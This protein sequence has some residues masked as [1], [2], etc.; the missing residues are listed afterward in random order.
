MGNI[1]LKSLQNIWHYVGLSEVIRGH[2]CRNDLTTPDTFKLTWLVTQY[3]SGP[4]VTFWPDSLTQTTRQTSNMNTSKQTT[5]LISMCER[6]VLPAACRDPIWAPL[7]PEHHRAARI[8]NRSREVSGRGDLVWIW[9]A[10]VNYVES[11]VNVSVCVWKASC[12][13]Q[14]EGRWTL[15]SISIYDSVVSS[16]PRKTFPIPFSSFIPLLVISS[17]QSVVLF[18]I[19][20]RFFPPFFQFYISWNISD[21]WFLRPPLLHL[22]RPESFSPVLHQLV[23]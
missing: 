19:S 13:N 15:D 17:N 1:S 22:N 6:G 8:F 5:S 23:I 9:L 21:P 14:A 18:F 12:Y 11:S 3:F 10:R 7:K 20:S 16:L 2:V 4:S